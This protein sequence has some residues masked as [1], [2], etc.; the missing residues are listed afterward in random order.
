MKRIT[1][2][3]GGA[4]GTL[5]AVNL[6]RNSGDKPLT[7]SLVEKRAEVG[8]GV[9][10]STDHD[11]HFLNVPAGKMSAFPD[12]PDNFH[13]W[14]LSNGFDYAASDFV[15]RKLYGRYLR[16][17]LDD[18]IAGASPNAVLNIINDEAENIIFEGDTANVI[19]HSGETIASDKVVLAFGNFPP[20]HPSVPDLRFTEQP[21]YVRNVWEKDILS[22]TDKDDAV[23]VIGTGL[24][25]VDVALRLNDGGHKGP[26]YVIS[27]RGL[28]PSVHKLGF[29]YEPFNDTLLKFERI[30]DILKEVR[31]R[32]VASSDHD[33]DWRA[34]IDSIRPATQ[35]L[36]LGLP[37]A[38][39]RYFMQH[40]S[41]H[42]NAARHRMPPQVAERMERMKA[43]EGFH[44]LSGRLKHISVTE[45]GRFLVN[46]TVNG[47]QNYLEVDAIMNCIASQANFSKIESPLVK[48]M[49]EAGLIRC[50][51]LCLGLDAL[52]NGALIGA[53]GK[54]SDKIFTLG[55]ALKG[56]LWETTAIPEIRVQAKELGKM[57]VDSEK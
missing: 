8:R 20:P 49:M 5:T 36:W 28:V 12:D 56:I 50:D 3:G 40:L 27:T 9:A 55:T 46:Y 38:E 52:P 16:E 44:L 23:L 31:K 7:I 32:A 30:T 10:Y 48:N 45:D 43:A 33:S 37:L 17:L 29:N 18:T 19:L 21:K 53:D 4:S 22:I 2:I 26:I 34:V 1:I 54:T 25:M 35:Q 24:S 14:L 51:A 11:L 47:Q 41:R 57:L 13:Q 39:K 6:L 42:W 15:P